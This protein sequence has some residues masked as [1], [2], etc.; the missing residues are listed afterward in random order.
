MFAF[1]VLCFLVVVVLASRFFSLSVAVGYFLLVFVVL[2]RSYIVHLCFVLVSVV[3]VFWSVCLLCRWLL[4]FACLVVG[5]FQFDRCFCFL[6][7][8]LGYIVWL[9][10][11][12]LSCWSDF[13]VSMIVSI[14]VTLLVDVVHFLLGLV[15]WFCTCFVF[16]VIILVAV[17]SVFY[18]V[19]APPPPMTLCHS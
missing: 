18:K 17:A 4:L 8:C 1:V 14:S 15:S 16:C 12:C 13:V 3:S 7:T 10:C 9:M 19:A 5:V 11:C 2:C 6:F